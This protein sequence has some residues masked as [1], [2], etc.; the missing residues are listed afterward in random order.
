MF[1]TFEIAVAEPHALSF[2][3]PDDF[4]GGDDYAGGN[5]FDDDTAYFTPPAP[6]K[7]PVSGASVSEHDS[8]MK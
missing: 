2:G 3:G 6:K 7:D 4:G 5:S 8:N 1:F